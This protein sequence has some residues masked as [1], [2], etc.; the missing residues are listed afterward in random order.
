MKTARKAILLVMCA[1]LLV[2]ASVMGTLAYL[3]DTEEVTNTFTVGKV[4]ITLDEKDTDNSSPNLERDKANKYHLLPGQTYVKDPTV[5]IKEGSDASYIRMLVNVSEINKLKAAFPESKYEDYYQDGVFLL[6]KLITGWNPAEWVFDN[7]NNGTYEFRYFEPVAG[8]PDNND[9]I[10][11]YKDLPALFQTI[12][13]PGTVNNTEL[14]E[15]QKIEI[16]VVAHAI[17]EASFADADAAWKAFDE[18]HPV[19]PNP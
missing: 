1:L 19:T 5:H 8:N 13:I 17:Q 15:L 3:T 7:Y 2:A 9:S 12:V 6:E 11:D 16:N 10:V 18:Q 4:D 14:A